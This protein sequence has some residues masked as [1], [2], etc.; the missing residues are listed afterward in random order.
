MKR[1]LPVLIL[2]CLTVGLLTLG[3]GS[4][5]NKA[6][7][8]EV[9]PSERAS[10]VAFTMGTVVQLSAYGP[11]AE[12]VLDLAVNELE[13]L[14]TVVD[15]FTPGSDIARLNAAAGEWV[16]VD[17]EVLALIKNALAWAEETDG[18]FDPT[19][20]P[21]IDL[22]GFVEDKEGVGG[23]GSSP[24][25][26]K[27]QRPPEHDAIV[28]TLQLVDY[29]QVA[30]DEKDFRV[31]LGSAGARLDLGG[32]AKGYAA[33]RVAAI[34][35]EHGIESGIIDLG[36]DM[37]IL[38]NKPDGTPWR[39][40]VTHPRVRQ[41]LAAVLPVTDA[42]VVTSGDYERYFEYEGVRYT[43]LIDPHTGYPQRELASVTVIAP[44]GA[45]AD[46]LATAVSVMGVERGRA[47]LER[48]PGVDGL[49]IDTEGNVYVTS[50]IEGKVEL[51]PAL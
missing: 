35:R 40:G 19:I 47:L 44:S 25:V 13:R 24:T 27:G 43:H 11:N 39:I 30:V 46:A 9:E 12:E 33:D 4:P 41:Q 10:R 17:A 32:I 45:A 34:F 7:Q 5:K 1:R 50:G 20:A 2:I 26:M 28:R 51:S 21:L 8:Q 29:T 3:C 6:D 18:A 36:G 37:Y 49:L 42:A 15:R 23:E 48:L 16:T 14:S 31:R 22:W 38:G